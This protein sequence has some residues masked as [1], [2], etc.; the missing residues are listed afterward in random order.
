MAFFLEH[1]IL[2]FTVILIWHYVFAV[3]DMLIPSVIKLQLISQF[4]INQNFATI[5]QMQLALQQL[6]KGVPSCGLTVILA[7]RV[8]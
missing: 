6:T 4:D 3:T 1:S 8:C 5:S 2:L 7:G